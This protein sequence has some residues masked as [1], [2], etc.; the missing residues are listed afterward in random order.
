M[1]SLSSTEDLLEQIFHQLN[2]AYRQI[3][4]HSS[5]TDLET[6]KNWPMMFANAYQA[7]WG[8]AA[9]HRPASLSWLISHRDFVV[10][11]LELAL[12]L[13]VQYA[14]TVDNAMDSVFISAKLSEARKLVKDFTLDLAR[15]DRYAGLLDEHHQLLLEIDPKAYQASIAARDS[16]LRRPTRSALELY[17]ASVNDAVDNDVLYFLLQTDAQQRSALERCSAVFEQLTVGT[18]VYEL[19]N[20]EIGE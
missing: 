10:K 15:Y 20:G 9:Q 19:M 18:L 14:E 8:M 17:I 4:R 7:T 3:L 16:Y 5:V 13:G 6:R 2:A 12:T 11:E 1:S